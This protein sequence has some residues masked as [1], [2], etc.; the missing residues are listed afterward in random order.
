[1][2][3]FKS[4]FHVRDSSPL[5]GNPSVTGVLDGDIS[6]EEIQIAAYVLRNGKSVGFDNISNEMLKCLLEARPDILKTVFNSILRNPSV[7]ESWSISMINPIHKAGSKTDPDNYRG[8]SLIS[9][10]SK[11]FS[12]ILNIRLTQY[13]IDNE[14]FSKSQLGFIAGCRTADALFIL[15]NL[16]EY[17]CK[18]NN[19][20]IF[21]CF[22]DFKKA[23]DSIPRHKLFQKLLNHN[24]TGKFYD[25][26]V[27]IYTNDIA[28]VKIVD[29]ITPVFLANQGVKQGCILSPTLFNIFL[30][31]FQSLVE[32]PNC[33]PVQLKENSN[34][35]CL[36]WADDILLL[37]KS[38]EGLE[39]MLLALKL[40]SERNGMA[41]N[42]KKTKVMIFN[43][44][45][46]HIRRVFKFGQ[47]KL[48]TT[49]QYKYLGFLVTPSGEINSGLRDLRDRAQHAFSK[50]KKKMGIT[51]RQK[52]S[53][54]IKLFS[55]LIEPILLY[56]SDF[57]GILK[58][59]GSNPIETLFMSFCKQLLGVQKQTTNAGVLLELGQLPLLIRARKKAI[60]IGLG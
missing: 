27:N 10:F 5:P 36:I 2:S 12:A 4:V 22:V 46:R 25:C 1:M 24:I 3:H 47:E 13:A 6:D 51:F 20:H 16:I 17:Y 11:L 37:S 34:I 23:F 56:A 49:R 29:H 33:D 38:K 45:G 53:I 19:Q 55:S 50:L 18:K 32:S 9:C 31:D 48:E 54:T 52:P 43:K 41:L 14:I 28:C 40:Y 30:A 35:G 21:G 59:P 15:T 60:K 58:M 44:N 42:A 8:I 39:N 57:W 26:L 7:I